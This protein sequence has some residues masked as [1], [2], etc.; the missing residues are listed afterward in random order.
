MRSTTHAAAQELRQWNRRHD[1]AREQAGELR[2]EAIDAFWRATW[3]W[4]TPQ[5]R[6]SVTASKAMPCARC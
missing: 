6:R 2:R 5:Q 4:L 1:Q 3:S